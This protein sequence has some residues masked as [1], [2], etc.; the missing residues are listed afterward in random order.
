MKKNY[1]KP[2]AEFIAFYSDEEIARVIPLDDIGDGTVLDK[3]LGD[4]EMPDNWT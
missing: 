2:D 4:A 3:S 1:L